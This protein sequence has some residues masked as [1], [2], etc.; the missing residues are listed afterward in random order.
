ME[1]V[2]MISDLV[3]GRLDE[4][5]L[6]SAARLA[7]EY[8]A[9]G[10]LILHRRTV[11]STFGSRRFLCRLVILVHLLIQEEHGVLDRLDAGRQAH[12]LLAGD[13]NGIDEV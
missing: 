5:L 10:G 9:S 7:A 4:L 1:F 3:G 13:L 11:G 8:L 2:L 12:S 6:S